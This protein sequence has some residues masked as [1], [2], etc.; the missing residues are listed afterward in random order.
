VAD[1][2]RPA[3]RVDDLPVLVLIHGGFWRAT[4]TK[5]L[6]NGLAASVIQHGW[7]AWNIEY[8]RV[9]MLGGGGGWPETFDDVA[10]AIDH[11]DEVP[12]V[13]TSQVVAVG[14][15]AGGQ[16]A[17]WA[18]ARPRLDA[19]RPGGPV[20]VSVRVTVSLAGI[21]DLFEADS[22]GLGNGATARLLGGHPD[23]CDERY[24]LA[25]PAALL[26]LGV[27]QVLVHGLAD[28]VVPPS[29]SQSYQLRA[30]AA[31]DQAR[32]L[33]IAGA[34]HRDL[35]DPQGPGWMGTLDVLKGL[36]A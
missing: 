23:Q 26:P 28:Q 17:L 32:Y 10:S 20:K 35:I 12:G 36:L 29:M 34:G 7:A 30:T 21:V 15:S 14:H 13:D 22:F 33:P 19:N 16:L 9:G 4:Y 3:D 5:M 6:M 31:G 8:R 24:R 11:L 25:S 27:P 18:A 2:W 1:L